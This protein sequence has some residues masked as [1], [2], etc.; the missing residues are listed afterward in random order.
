MFLIRNRN[1]RPEKVR[2]GTGHAAP[3]KH[4]DASA[5]TLF[6]RLPPGIDKRHPD[7][8]VLDIDDPIHA[9]RLLKELGHDIEVPQ[10]KDEEGI[11]Q[12]TAQLER[13]VR[14]PMASY[15]T[16]PAD[17]KA[18]RRAIAKA[19]TIEKKTEAPPP[20]GDMRLNDALEGLSALAEIV[21]AQG[22]ALNDVRRKLEKLTE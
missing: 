3:L 14:P 1:P 12:L 17:D 5:Y 4:L 21:E 7:Y 8:D 6:H 16:G 10:K 15:K 9:A 22:E 18:G 13:I 2:D 19:A 20:R 11:A